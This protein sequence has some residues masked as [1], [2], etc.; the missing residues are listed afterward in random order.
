[1][2]PNENKL[3]SLL[4][5]NDVTF[6][7]PP[8][9]RNYEWD[10]DSCEAFL[11]DIIKTIRNINK[12]NKIYEHFF[13][14]VTYF[15]SKS[16][17][18]QPTELVLIDG[19]QRITTTMLFLIALRDSTKEQTIKNYIDSHYLKNNN[20]QSDSDYK[21]KLKQ[22]QS[23]WEP[24]SNLV[25]GKELSAQQ[26]LS[27]IYINYQFF[28]NRIANIISNKQIELM[29]LV[30]K[31]L[32]NFSVVTVE[33]EPKNPWENPQEIFESMNSLGKPLSLADLVRNYILLS[34]SPKEQNNL[35]KKYWTKIEEDLPNQVS[36]FIRDFMQM[37][38]AKA[39]KKATEHNYKELYANF[40][41]C[42]VNKDTEDLLSNLSRFSKY[43]A[44]IVFD[45]KTG[46]KN[47]DRQ[48]DN[49]RILN[50]T[51]SYS[52]IMK[53]LMYWDNH[54]LSD[55][56]FCSVLKAFNI[57]ILRRRIVSLNQAENKIFP[58]LVD[59]I[60]EI[61]KSS[62]KTLKTYDV[63]SSLENSARLPNDDEISNEL[64]GLNFYNFR[65][66]KF[67][68][69]LIEESL[70]KAHLDLSDPYLQIEHIM[71]QNI[72]RD[73]WKN[74]LGSNYSQVHTEL[75]NNIGN[76]TLIRRN[77]ELGNKSFADKKNVYLESEGLQIARTEITNREVWNKESI[78]NRKKWLVN[79]LLQKV[80][81]I[82]DER[83]HLN[84]FN[85]EKK[86]ALSFER[87]SLIGETINYIKDESIVAKVVSDTEVEFEGAIWKLSTLTKEIEKRRNTLTP[88]GS[89]SGAQYWSYDGERLYDL[90]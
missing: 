73:V 22:V 39:F 50:V 67:V 86:H 24:Y 12:T 78:L 10:R 66:A 43:Y 84:N 20:T 72:D 15:A 34:K 63:L 18:G 81:V 65:L 55:E 62:D 26:K 29:D 69:S 19:Q 85:I 56:D 7:I 17:F 48:L 57:Y 5:N 79:Q 60:D 82:P 70:T 61:V 4:S 35:Y 64:D 52:F 53:L 3:L 75:L 59:K 30:Q 16:V 77:Q 80:L 11:N 83:R 89:Y 8:Y 40:K 68:L 32:N 45:T 28:K 54:T 46:N 23:D 25:Q 37:T 51:T 87:L 88:S 90:L 2:K 58:V 42:Y 31:G 76:L 41:E 1:M 14:T 33:L 27:K 9:Q 71:P 74:E 38:E 13:G 21:I 44:Y 47:I 49:L 36:N 6:F